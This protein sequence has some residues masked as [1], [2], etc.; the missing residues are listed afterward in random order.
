ML[1]RVESQVHSNTLVDV[2]CMAAIVAVEAVGFVGH[3]ELL[4]VLWVEAG[5]Y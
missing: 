1:H 5:A 2:A 3:H 4:C